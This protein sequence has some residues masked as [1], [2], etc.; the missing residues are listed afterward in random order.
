MANPFLIG[1]KVYL[2]PLEQEDARTVQPWLNDPDIR[3]FGQMYS[4][5]SL[6]DEEHFIEKTNQSQSDVICMIVRQDLNQPIGVTGLHQIDYRNG[7]CLF[8]I[9]IGDKAAW[10]MGFGTEATNLIVGYA[11]HT[12][13]LHRVSLVVFD[14]N[15]RARSI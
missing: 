1:S 2:R 9:I 8:G 4:P 13:N 3:Q 5:L 7:D 14:F 12:L 6:R 11:F 10:G 15:E